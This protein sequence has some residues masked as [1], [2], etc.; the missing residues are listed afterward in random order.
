MTLLL[1]HLDLLI[2]VV[3][4]WL[5]K[6]RQLITPPRLSVLDNVTSQFFPSR[7]KT[8]FPTPCDVHWLIECSRNDNVPVPSLGFR[9]HCTPFCLFC[10]LHVPKNL[11]GLVS[12]E[13]RVHMEESPAVPDALT[14]N[15]FR[16]PAKISRAALTS[17]L[18]KIVGEPG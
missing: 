14:R 9:R 12:W 7:A 2:P 16:S 13:M 8:H 3:A 10:H 1:N 6:W 5:Q 15:V 18:Q 4:D 11:P 17:S